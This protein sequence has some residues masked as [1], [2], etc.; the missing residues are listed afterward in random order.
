[1]RE[2]LWV[3][4]D[5]GVD[6]DVWDGY[7]SDEAD[8]QLKAL[9]AEVQNSGSVA[10]RGYEIGEPT[11]LADGTGYEV[12]VAL[13][14]TGQDGGSVQW[15]EVTALLVKES[16]TW[17]IREFALGELR[18]AAPTAAPAGAV[19]DKAAP[20]LRPL[21]SYEPTPR[22]PLPSLGGRLLVYEEA[23]G[24]IYLMNADGTGVTPL[25]YG[26]DPAW[27]PDGQWI[28][29]ARWS[30]PRGLYLIRPD[31]SDEHLLY[32]A[33]Q[34]R[35]PA[36]SPDGEWIAFSVQKGG[37]PESE[38]CFGDRCFRI[39]PDSYWRL[40][41]VRSW[42]GEF[43]DIPSDF[44]S[45]SPSWSPDG[46]WLLYSGDKGIKR[47]N[48]VT[49][50]QETVVEE[51]RLAAPAWSPDGTRIVY[52]GYQH[53]HWDLYSRPAWGSAGAI[54]L[55]SPSALL[56]QTWESI[57]PTFSP[58]GEWVAFVSN[59]GG[60]WGLYAVPTDGGAIRPLIPGGLPDGLSLTFNAQTQQAVA[61]G[62]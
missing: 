41:M 11:L 39:P 8:P 24:Q 50:E 28:A 34:I 1:V 57:A 22:P 38:I 36:W 37:K 23:G 14:I 26:L 53:D 35:T 51:L 4:L 32:G 62:P 33:T 40:A 56:P 45:F 12:P 21:P 13:Q 10:A 25:T 42:D 47:L 43:R 7:L 27:S 58:D 30:D 9:V 20:A 15:Q 55:T 19:G 54:R 6:E 2:F 18:E 60:E 29:F 3:L 46:V 17:R 48:L 59:P 5:R 49:E 16:H 61:W 44:H 31:G 52:M